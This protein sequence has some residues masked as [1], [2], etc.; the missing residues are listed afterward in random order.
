MAQDGCRA[1]QA[2]IDAEGA[3]PMQTPCGPDVFV[4]V[5]KWSGLKALEAH[6]RS[7]HMIGY[8]ESKKYDC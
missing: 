1:Y 2:T 7:P 3:G 4:I 8:G 5:E 6:A